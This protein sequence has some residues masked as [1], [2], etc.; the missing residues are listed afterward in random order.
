MDAWKPSLLYN[1][2]CVRV[3]ACGIGRFSTVHTHVRV[4]EGGDDMWVVVIL[5]LLLMIARQGM[6][7][8]PK[9]HEMDP[10]IPKQ[11]SEE[12]DALGR[13][14]IYGLLIFV[15]VVVLLIL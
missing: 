8:V 9:A 13:A 2:L 5:V 6:A 10:R 3:C 7:N 1:K 11:T 4:G 14:L 12:W 15:F